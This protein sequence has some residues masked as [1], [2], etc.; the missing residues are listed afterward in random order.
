MR[1]LTPGTLVP[2]SHWDIRFALRKPSALLTWSCDKCIRLRASRRRYPMYLPES[3][4][5]EVWK[6]FVGQGRTKKFLLMKGLYRKHYEEKLNNTLL[7][8]RAKTTASY[9]SLKLDLDLRL[10]TYLD[11]VNRIKK[12][13]T[14][15][16]TDP[17]QRL[18]I[19]DWSIEVFGSEF[20]AKYTNPATSVVLSSR[21]S[22]SQVEIYPN[23][24]NGLVSIASS[25]TIEKLAIV[26]VLGRQVYRSQPTQKTVQVSLTTP[27]AYFVFVTTRIGT[28][29][30]KVVISH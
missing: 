8:R 17:F 30:K 15:W 18:G 4:M 27:G 26:D 14:L 11:V 13:L 23:P 24:S 6:K 21:Q 19:R 7:G 16:R 10:Y 9:W 20:V 28:Y 3:S 2:F 5:W 1:F 25:D 29:A 22:V 12:Q